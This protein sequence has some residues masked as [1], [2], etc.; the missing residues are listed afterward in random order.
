MDEKMA[1]MSRVAKTNDFVKEIQ[2][3]ILS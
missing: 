2:V 3:I 1:T